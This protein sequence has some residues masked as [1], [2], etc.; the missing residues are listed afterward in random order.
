MN[1][2]ELNRINEKMEFELGYEYIYVVSIFLFVCFYV[3][4]QPI[5]P[6]FAVIGLLF[7]Y[8]IEKYSL[9]QRSQRPVP[10]TDVVSFT[11]YQMIYFGAAAYALGSLTWSAFLPDNNFRN[12]LVPNL[13][14]A[15]LSVVIFFFPYGA[16]AEKR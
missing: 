6:I 12:S 15:G 16:F 11:M 2:Y 4:L 5:I 1:Q 3:S 10:G 7:M 9:F 13:I 14:A 8:W